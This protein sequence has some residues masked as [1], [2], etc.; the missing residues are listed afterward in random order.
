MI[1]RNGRLASFID[2][3]S[4]FVSD[5]TNQREDVF[6]KD[7]SKGTVIRIN[8]SAVGA[9]S[10]G[11]S[12][13]AVI[14]GTGY[15][16]PSANV[17]FYSEATTIATVGNG[18][19]GNIYKVKLTFPPPPLSKDS[20]IE[21]PPDVTVKKKQVKLVLQDF[22]LSARATGI[23][24]LSAVTASAQA[25]TYDI[26]LLKLGSKKGVRRSSKTN[27]VTLRNLTAGKYTVRYRVSGK[28]SGK[29]VTTGYSPTITV[30]VTG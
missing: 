1:N 27:T 28:V 26:R 8:K 25:A 18:T 4:V 7:L 22:D 5:D 19:I 14:G 11:A 9:Q 6:V 24:L 21:S 13:Q 2:S 10:D 23:P 3:S 30:V 17:A 16:R 15:S 20:K 29:T 12:R